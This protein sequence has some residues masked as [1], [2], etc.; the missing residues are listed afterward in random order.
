MYRVS[1]ALY[2]LLYYVVRYRRRVVAEN[3]ARA[4]PEK[5][6]AERRQIEKKFYRHLCDISLEGIKGINA[7][8]AELKARYKIINPH[9]ILDLAPQK[10][11]ALAVSAHVANW[12]W[13]PGGASSQ[14][15]HQIIVIY[16]ALGNARIDNY[17][18]QRHQAQHAQLRSTKETRLAFSEN[19]DKMS[20]FVLLG[21]QNPSNRREA[22]WVD[23]FGIPTATLHG[24]SKYAQLYNLPVV[25]FYAQRVGRGFYEID[26]ELLFDDPNA[27]TPQEISQRFMQKVEQA[28]RLQPH[29]WLWSHRRW[30]YTQDEV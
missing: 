24:I 10:R 29:N 12:E 30:K 5:S 28:I 17:I 11:S 16:K 19:Q 2:Y 4:F 22:H 15:P 18:R 7:S 21:D 3:L 1:D 23:F 9:P 27:Q 13:G 20:L 8:P 25:F 14:L 6:A 26:A